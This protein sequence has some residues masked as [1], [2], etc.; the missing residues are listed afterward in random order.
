[1]LRENIELSIIVPVHNEEHNIDEFVKSINKV[2]ENI[3]EIKKNYEL[4]FVL[5]PSDDQTE[6]IIRD[7][8]KKNQN[9]S[10]IKMSRRFGQAA[11]TIAGIENCRGKYC[12]VIDVDFQD[13]PE[14]IEKLYKKIVQGYDVVNA[15]RKSRSG[16]NFFYK[17][18]TYTGYKFINTFSET[19][20]PSNTGD[21]RIFNKKIVNNLKNL[22]E[23]H[24]FLR[25]L[26]SFVGFNQTHILYDR[27][28]RYKGK[29]HYSRI[30][31]SLKIAVNGLVCYSNFL[32]NFVFWLG[33]GIA[34]LACLMSIFL[35]MNVY[36]G[37]KIYPIGLSSIILSILFIGG[38][39]LIS[40]GIVGQ[41]IARIYD[42]T[43]DRPKY[44]IDEKVNI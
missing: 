10:L 24:N 32:L 6:Q 26:I 11:C 18:L 27:K 37:S 4:I 7:Y 3:N 2:C 14:V 36:F 44:I 20:I 40:L 13:P 30:F 17:L 19:N 16:I 31:G 28:E 43:K 12:V 9:I 29:S 38:V 5:D 1:M 42:E 34:F 35:V 23:K 22:K 41:Y 25:G 33:L 39:Q 21:F 15:K 8:C